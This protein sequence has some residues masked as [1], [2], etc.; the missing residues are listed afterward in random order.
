MQD[1]V[2]LLYSTSEDS[3]K[4][5]FM[6]TSVWARHL[7]LISLIFA[8]CVH[9][10]PVPDVPNNGNNNGGN[11]GTPPPPP[12]TCSS[13]T[14]YFSNTILPLVNSLCGKS[15]CHGTTYPN[16]FQMTNYSSIVS[17]IGTSGRLSHALNEMADQK[18]ENPNLNYTAP[19][20][21]QLALL[22]KWISQGAKNNICNSCDTTQFTYAAIISP[23]IATYCKGCHSGSAPAAGVDLSTIASIQS[24]LANNPGRL[25][26]S[27][28][29]TAP[30]TGTKEMPQGGSQLPTCYITQ[31]K[32][33]IQ[34][35]A[36]NN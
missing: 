19:T 12:A 36:P 26:G 27:I 31:I 14:V 25:L 2:E 33:W 20:S 23:I 32:K 10:L 8:S 3:K 24:E 29:W 35:G 16:A 18:S 4:K 28:Q 1:Y 17:H 30:Y 7:F 6:Q 11:G 34:A 13:D 22:N 21:E 5:S 9:E 15:G